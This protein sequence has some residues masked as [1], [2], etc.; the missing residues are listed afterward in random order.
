MSKGK[1]AMKGLEHNSYG[2]RQRL[3][4]LGLFSREKRMLRGD[5]ITL[6]NDLKGGWSEVWVSLFSR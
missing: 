2:E 1:E 5:L 4:D 3:R 6:Y